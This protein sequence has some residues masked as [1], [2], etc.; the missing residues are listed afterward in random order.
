M[1][2][3]GKGG[4][5]M[6]KDEF[7]DILR[8][9]LDGEVSPDIIEQNIKYYDHYISTN[10]IKDE[11][12]VLNELGHP[13]L[14]AKT[15]IESEK[16]A[17]EKGK[18]TGYRGYREEYSERNYD[19]EEAQE[20]RQESYRNF[21]NRRRSVFFTGVRWYHKVILWTILIF[22]L[23]LLLFIGRVIIRLLYVFAVPII[24]VIL[25]MSLFRRR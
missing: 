12:T 24:L 17:R 3:W 4:G 13:R 14:I 21:G 7:L 11:G 16:I 22:F 6:N 23:L 20:E 2:E 15:I 25:L 1:I 19:K 9:A 10:S 18:S 5:S 8:Q